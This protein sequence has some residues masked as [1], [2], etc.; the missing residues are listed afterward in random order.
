MKIDNE[1]I[2]FE[3]NDIKKMKFKKVTGHSFVGLIGYDSFNKVGDTLLYM[4]NI[5]PNIVD[6]KYF[7]RGE[8]AEEIIYKVYQRDYPKDEIIRYED[9]KAI[10]YDN[11]EMIYTNLGGI[12]DIENLSQNKI[13]EV[14]SKSMKDYEKIQNVKPLHEV[15]Q[16]LLYTFLRHYDDLTMEWVF[17][18]EE[19]ENLL[20]NG[21]KPKTNKNLKR[22]SFDIKCDHDEM[23]QLCQKAL[24]IVMNFRKEFKIKLSDISPKNIELLKQRM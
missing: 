3:E 18:D 16:G 17:F 5:L 9:K 24:R 21:E 22:I 19:S 15:Y 7:K 13:I 2:I 20:F 6:S 1:Y 23:K 10:N 11:F 12:I 14:K 4:H 8:Y